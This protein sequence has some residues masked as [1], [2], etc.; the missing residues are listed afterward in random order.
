MNK[1]ITLLIFLM[2][3]LTISAN[4]QFLEKFS[5]YEG[6]DSARN[7]VSSL[8]YENPK[9]L[10][11]L[12]SNDSLSLTGIPISVLFDMNTGKSEVWIYVFAD[13][14]DTTKITGMITLNTVLGFVTYPFGLEDFDVKELVTEFKY[15]DDVNWNNSDFFAEKI[16]NNTEYNEFYN[17]HKPLSKFQIALAVNSF[18]QSLNWGE[19]YWL[20][21]V[22]GN[23]A[24]HEC[25]VHSLL[26]TTDCNTITS[27][28]LNEII[29]EYLK[30][31]PNPASDYINIDLPEIS[32]YQEIVFYIYDLNGNQIDVFEKPG[33]TKQVHLSL[34][35]KEYSNGIYIIRYSINNHQYSSPFI[36]ER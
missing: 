2:L 5:A 10:L 15:L 20:L 7:S 29:N 30:V 1:F 31:F 23:D 22:E 9:L 27:V 17:S 18:Y 33:D 26:G 34:N 6:L 28:A 3:S 14:A 4:A 24:K 13:A 35:Q 8:G 12:T 25:S 16:R 32:N 19:A 21:Q 11:V 36:I